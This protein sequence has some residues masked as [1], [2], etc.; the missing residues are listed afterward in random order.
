MQNGD[1]GVVLVIDID[2][3]FVKNGG[4]VCHCKLDCADEGCLVN[5]WCDV[6]VVCWCSYSQGQLFNS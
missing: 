6:Y 5:T 3:I 1:V 2:L 4:V